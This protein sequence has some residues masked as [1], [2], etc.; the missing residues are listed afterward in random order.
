[1]I[2]DLEHKNVKYVRTTSGTL[3]RAAIKAYGSWE[4][5]IKA[6]GLNYEDIVL[7]RVRGKDEIIEYI[8]LLPNKRSKYNQNNNGYLYSAAVRMFGSWKAAIVAAGFDYNDIMQNEWWDKNRVIKEIRSLDNMTAGDVQGNNSSLMNAAS[9]YFGSWKEA[10]TSAGFD[11]SKI[12]TITNWSKELVIVE[13]KE[14]SNM[15]LR[16]VRYHRVDLLR[17]AQ[18]YHGSWRDAIVAAGF[19]YDKIRRSYTGEKELYRILKN[20][21]PHT[22]N[23]QKTFTWL[24]HKKNLYL[25]FYIPIYDL[26]IEYQGKQH[27]V[28]VKF[29]GVSEGTAELEFTETVARDMVK[30]QLL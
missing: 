6:C 19:D 29:G 24:K 1:M 9:K 21:L 25:D 26:A 13:I 28:P 14:L 8:R 3:Y 17:A 16:Y 2:C 15:S 5:A 23:Q 18:K 27:Y 7:C 11:Y 12:I 22:I 10:V 4:S 20:V 30:R